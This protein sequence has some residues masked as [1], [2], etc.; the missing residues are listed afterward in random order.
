MIEI[1]KD[2]EV[3]RQHPIEMSW[4]VPAFCCN[5]WIA[6]RML[7]LCE[8]IGLRQPFDIVYGAPRC[9]WAGGRPSVVATELSDEQLDMYFNAYAE[10][11]VNVAL[12]L[13]RLVV[14]PQDYE[15]AYCKRI[16]DAAARWDAE[17]ILFDDG[18]ADHIRSTHPNLK[19]ICSL[20]RAMC[21]YSGG[22]GGLDETEYY[23]SLLKR[24]DEVVIRCE[25]AQ[26]DESLRALSDVSSRC[27][28]I[29]NQFC[30]PNCK[31]VFRHVSTMENW[32]HTA[33]AHPCYSMRDA[34]NLTKRLTDNLHVSN[35]RINRFAELNFTK[36]KL[37]GRNAPVPKFL[38]ML[39][40][41]IFEPT[42]IA[43]FLREELSRQYRA[44]SLQAGGH[45]PPFWLP[46]KMELTLAE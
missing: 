41:Y 31:N 42:G 4:K 7:Q 16:L 45:I 35:A 12:T 10:H 20:N 40:N 26:D 23:H 5:D 2:L 44:A 15:D 14:D 17:L 34:G 43:P 36:M 3:Y 32:E 21:D 30:V 22:F 8:A 13:S 38:D 29:V 9:A 37:A 18:L 1:S 11:N 33:S 24:Y 25:Y 39:S 46:E 27:E 19:L 6:V 28:I